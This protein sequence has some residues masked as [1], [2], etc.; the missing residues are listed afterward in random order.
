MKEKE[1]GGHTENMYIDENYSWVRKV[2]PRRRNNEK[3]RKLQEIEENL[4]SKNILVCPRTTWRG[5]P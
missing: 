4:A 2:A 3:E 5:V 1:Y